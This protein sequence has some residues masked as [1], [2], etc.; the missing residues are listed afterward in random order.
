MA[1][2]CFRCNGWTADTQS[3]SCVYDE[4]EEVREENIRLREALEYQSLNN[5]SYSYLAQEA[6][7]NEPMRESQKEFLIWAR[8]QPNPHK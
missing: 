8:T 6:L 5:H 7:D 1:Y 4:V 2:Q 3:H